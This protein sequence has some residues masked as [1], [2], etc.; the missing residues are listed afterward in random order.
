M[1]TNYNYPQLFDM[2]DTDLFHGLNLSDNV[3]VSSSSNQMYNTTTNFDKKLNQ[4]SNN[5]NNQD[6]YNSL[7]SASN[8]TS[9]YLH[10]LQSNNTDNNNNNHNNEFYYET[11]SQ[12]MLMVPPTMDLTDYDYF[13]QQT[14]EQKQQYNWL[15]DPMDAFLPNQSNL[16]CDNP[17]PN[18][19]LDSVMTENMDES[20]TV[21]GG[22]SRG[23]VSLSVI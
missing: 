18:P 12:V 22:M 23:Y 17:M 16:F 13:N 21:E 20:I 10:Y 8:N 7:A 2:D 9:S 3:T 4:Q 15:Y 6:I 19:P 14:T 5:N 11:P 1:D